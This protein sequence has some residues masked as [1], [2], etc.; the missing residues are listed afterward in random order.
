M[1]KDT[2]DVESSALL[3]KDS[4][5]STTT[6][7]DDPV[8][9]LL[10]ERRPLLARG[11]STVSVIGTVRLTDGNLI[12]VPPATADPRGTRPTLSREF[13]NIDQMLRRSI[14]Y[15]AMAED[16]HGHCGLLL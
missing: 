15:E 1:R 14:E 12:Y 9:E 3:S 10:G 5:T 13:E 4:G 11:V 16:N 8:S 6:P 7:S 2:E